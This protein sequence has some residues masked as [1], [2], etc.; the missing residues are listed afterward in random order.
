MLHMLIFNI[1]NIIIKG[2][3]VSIFN[4]LNVSHS[5]EE[6]QNLEQSLLL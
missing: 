2:Y 6:E 5:Y 3:K 1:Y 4:I